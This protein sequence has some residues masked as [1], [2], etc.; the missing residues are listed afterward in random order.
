MKSMNIK[1]GLSKNMWKKI[2]MNL[3]PS[4]NNPTIFSLKRWRP[5]FTNK[6]TI[7]SRCKASN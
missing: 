7:A 5:S 3:T 6:M 1:K 4:P 2:R